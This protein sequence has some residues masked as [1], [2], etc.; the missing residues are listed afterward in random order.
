M[1]D[2]PLHSSILAS[3][4][5]PRGV[6][7][8]ARS[9]P[10]QTRYGSPTPPS[11]RSTGAPLLASGFW[12]LL[13]VV[14]TPGSEWVFLTNP[15]GEVLGLSDESSSWSPTT[16]HASPSA[17]D[18]A[19]DCAAARDVR[20]RWISGRGRLRCSS[21]SGHALGTRGLATRR[22]F[23]DH[24]SGVRSSPL[25]SSSA[26]VGG[27]CGLA[28]ISK[29]TSQRCTGRTSAS[30]DRASLGWIFAACGGVLVGRHRRRKRM[31]IRRL[32]MLHVG[33][34]TRV[35][36]HQV[37]ELSDRIVIV[38]RWSGRSGGG[39]EAEALGVAASVMPA[40]SSAFRKRFSM[41]VGTGPPGI[42]ADRSR[43]IARNSCR[44]ASSDGSRL[45]S[46]ALE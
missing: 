30:A 36:F 39:A 42:I 41:S 1:P 10:T 26:S 19:D 6:C 5:A 43:I 28:A 33:Q 27:V 46:T 23:G 29:V 45:T 17:T 14:V 24:L 20:A 34:E 16:T 9:S 21:A 25:L 11:P 35:G 3:Q 15:R 31:Y 12:H 7:A 8:H 44:Y 13:G 37:R 32:K 40:S 18:G 38:R 2:R 22:A 4:R